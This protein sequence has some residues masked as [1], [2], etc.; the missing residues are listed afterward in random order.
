MLTII[1]LSFAL[2]SFVL[3]TFWNPQPTRYNLVAL[4][5]AFYMLSLLAAFKH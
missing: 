5:L 3:G 4:G 2:L 1:L